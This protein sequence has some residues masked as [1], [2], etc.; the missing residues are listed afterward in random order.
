MNTYYYTGDAEE[1]ETILRDG[2]ID[3]TKRKDTGQLGVCVADSPGAPSNP[4]E[5]LLKI[6]LPAQIDT[7]RWRLVFPDNPGTWGEWLLPAHVL[8]EHARVRQLREDQWKE[9]CAKYKKAQIL[10]VQEELIAEGLFEHAKDSH[11]RPLY[12]NGKPV[13]RLTEKGRQ[14]ALDDEE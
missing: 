7:S 13:W 2:F 8:N 12:R 11:G 5:G 3:Y 14:Q 6:T 1:I 4:N 10:K 9:A